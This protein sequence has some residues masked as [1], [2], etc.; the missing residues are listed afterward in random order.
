MINLSSS[1]LFLYSIKN[2]LK[3]KIARGTKM[4]TETEQAPSNVFEKSVS[5]KNVVGAAL[6]S[7][8][9]GAISADEQQ[10]TV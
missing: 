3:L 7:L 6:C 2:L 9:G 4:K 10:L 8:N 1:K 5:E